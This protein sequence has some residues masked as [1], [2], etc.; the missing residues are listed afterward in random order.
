[1]SVNPRPARETDDDHELDL[2]PLDGEEEDRERDD[3]ED[4]AVDED[5]EDLYDDAE[6]GDELAAGEL[7]EV[8]EER[9]LEGAESDAALDVGETDDI[10]ADD[11]DPLTEGDV[12]GI[13]EEE[14]DVSESSEP[15]D[16][17][18][19]GPTAPDEELREEDLPALDADDDGLFE[20]TDL[21]EAGAMEGAEDLPRA[22]RPYE[23]LGATR[24][25]GEPHAIALCGEVALVA[26]GESLWSVSAG[27]E[28]AGAWAGPC[29]AVGARDGVWVASFAGQVRGSRDQGRTWA[30][31]P[32]LTSALAPPPPPDLSARPGP[33]EGSLLLVENGP[34]GA[35]VVFE[36]GAESE[37]DAPAV[38]ALVARD[39]PSGTVWLVTPRGVVVLRAPSA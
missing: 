14:L 13:P 21:L 35:R 32:G 30:A 31:D 15:V 4:M 37:D 7:G 8:A 2:P 11:G 25:L 22:A 33:I 29:D 10:A 6:A 12:P 38:P 24:P 20:E 39:A 1:M 5:P 28:V 17:G 34:E 26:A 9:W 23:I 36:L 27:G 19:E 16:A 3:P 18:D